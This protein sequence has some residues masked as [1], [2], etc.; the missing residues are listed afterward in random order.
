MRRLQ[1]P[2]HIEQQLLDNSVAAGNVRGPGHRLVSCLRLFYGVFEF[3]RLA[4]ITGRSGRNVE[5]VK[6][7]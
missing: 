3:V 6:V 4:N 1:R 2:D 7:S 5:C